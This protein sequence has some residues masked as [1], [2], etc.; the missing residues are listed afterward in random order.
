MLGPDDVEPQLDAATNVTAL[1]TPI[2]HFG[3]RIA[4][5]VGRRAIRVNDA[6]HA[7]M[8]HFGRA[9]RR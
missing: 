5:I 9:I 7:A 4:R 6:G 3:N 1:N 8:T 2:D